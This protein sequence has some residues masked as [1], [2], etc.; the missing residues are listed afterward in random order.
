MEEKIKKNKI[1]ICYDFDN[2]L[3]PKD[4][5]DIGITTV[6]GTT[7]SDFLKESNQLC[8]VHNADKIHTFMYL[9]MKKHLDNGVVLTRKMIEDCGKNVTYFPGVETWFERINNYAKEQGFEVEHYIISSGLKPVIDKC[10]IA[11]YFKEIYASD[12]LYNEKGEAVWTAISIN[13]TNKTQFLYRINKGILSVIDDNINSHMDEKDRPIPFENL[14]YIGDSF[15]DIPAFRQI[16]KAGGNSI[17]VYGNNE[18]KQEMAQGLKDMNKVNYAV[19]VDYSEGK[20][21]ETTVK[22]IIDGLKNKQ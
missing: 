1:A 2:T 3:S 14:I 10:S 17:C 11:K 18:R 16:M 9:I 21:L 13:Y 5:Q 6:M 12:Y 8:D 7:I 19:E 4:T 20:E 15:T 22:N